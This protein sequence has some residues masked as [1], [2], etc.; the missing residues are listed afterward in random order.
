MAPRLA[1]ADPRATPIFGR[2]TPPATRTPR[3]MN[4]LVYRPTAFL[5]GIVCA[6]LALVALLCGIGI[7]ALDEV[8]DH[9]LGFGPVRL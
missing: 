4:L 9:L 8:R 7:A 5:L 2:P 6:V 1:L 3:P